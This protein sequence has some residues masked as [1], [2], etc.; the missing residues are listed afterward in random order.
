MKTEADELCSECGNGIKPDETPHLWRGGIVCQACNSKLNRAPSTNSST[1]PPS[2]PTLNIAA[3]LLLVASVLVIAA[4]VLTG[5][6]RSW[7][8]GITATAGGVVMLAMGEALQAFRNM[9]IDTWHI[10]HD[11]R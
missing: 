8:D 3:R 4:G 7:V 1:K 6:A 9:V 10:R 11:R 2:Y 5:M